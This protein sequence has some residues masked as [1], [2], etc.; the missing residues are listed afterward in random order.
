MRKLFFNIVIG[1][2]ML[3]VLISCVGVV[4]FLGASIVNLCAGQY[5]QGG[6]L[7]GIAGL[8]FVAFAVTLC[9]GYLFDMWES[10]DK[11]YKTFENE[12]DD[13]PW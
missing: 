5:V 6:K 1:F 2:F 3:F 7:L 10:K 13:V 11:R 9:L 12:D 4:G 8:S